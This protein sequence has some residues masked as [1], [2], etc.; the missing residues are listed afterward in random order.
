MTQYSPEL[1]VIVMNQYRFNSVITT[2]IIAP[3]QTSQQSSSQHTCTAVTCATSRAILARLFDV[4][5]YFKRNIL[6]STP[7]LKTVSRISRRR[8]PATIRWSQ[9]VRAAPAEISSRASRASFCA[10]ASP[11]ALKDITN[12]IGA[13]TGSLANG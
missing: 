4:R 1:I 11:T 13:P 9:C 5:C 7:Q 8:S 2:I 6:N 12:D 10:R 3:H